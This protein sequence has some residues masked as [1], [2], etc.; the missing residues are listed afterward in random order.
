[1]NGDGRFDEGEFAGAEVQHCGRHLPVE[2]HYYDL[3]LAPDGSS[4]RVAPTAAR[5]ATV[6]SPAGPFAL[7]LSRDGMLAVRGEDG[8]A[9]VP[10][11]D[12]RIAGWQVEQRDREGSV[13]RVQGSRNRLGGEAPRLL[14]HADTALP[15]LASPLLAR[16]EVQPAG[17]REF[18]CQLNFTGA[19][20][21]V[22]G[23]VLRNGQQMPAPDMRVLD[24]RGQEIARV[25]FHYG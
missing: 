9:Q 14:V 3:E 4:F 23:Q 11:G 15:R 25:P 16:L 13:W 24:A 8:R 21:E 10:V 19:S 20:G 1:M 17:G 7:L 5:L 22:I 12:Y 18:S 2:G 6:S